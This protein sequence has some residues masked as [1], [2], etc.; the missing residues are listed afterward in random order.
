MQTA[1]LWI[2][3]ALLVAGGLIGFF[4]AGSKMSIITAIA[5]AIPL[6]LCAANVITVKWVADVL[7]AVLLVFFAMRFSKSK[8]FMPGGMMAAASAI[9]LAIHLFAK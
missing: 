2:Y 8:K 4:K 7:V 5:F 9:T 1:I 6:S 3:V